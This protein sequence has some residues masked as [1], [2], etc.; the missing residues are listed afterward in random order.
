MTDYTGTAGKAAHFAAEARAANAAL[1]AVLDLHKRNI[2][3]GCTSCVQNRYPCPTVRAIT[4]AI[5]GGDA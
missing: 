1:Q 5:G 4:D 2:Y 3:G